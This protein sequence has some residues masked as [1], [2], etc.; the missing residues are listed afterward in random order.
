[1]RCAGVVQSGHGAVAWGALTETVICAA[2]WST[3]Q[4]AR[5][6]VVASGNKQARTSGVWVVTKVLSSSRQ[7]CLWGNA[8][9]VDHK[10]EV[11]HKRVYGCIRYNHEG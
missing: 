9:D 5:H 3:W 8:G 4:A 7:R 10:H 11:G 6:R 2:G 1:M